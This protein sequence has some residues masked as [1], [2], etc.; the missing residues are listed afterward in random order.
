LV[1]GAEQP[2]SE[3]AVG[4]HIG[5]QDT[6]TNQSFEDWRSGYQDSSDE[7]SKYIVLIIGY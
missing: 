2:H 7:L 1:S 5:A 3:H 4:A 6:G